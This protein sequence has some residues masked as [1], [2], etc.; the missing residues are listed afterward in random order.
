VFR[1]SFILTLVAMQLLVGSSRATYLCVSS[2]GSL[3]C[4]DSGPLSCSCCRHEHDS[5]AGEE[6]C[7]EVATEEYESKCCCQHDDEQSCPND[8]QL[9]ETKDSPAFANGA[10]SCTHEL[11]ST[12]QVGGNLRSS[13]SNQISNALQL[14]D[15]LPTASYQ[16]SVVVFDGRVCWQGPPPL[17]DVAISVLS[18]V[19]IRC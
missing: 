11:V 13:V 12:G 19:A 15:C 2:D 6:A 10:C 9:P 16:Q 5:T 8:S 3:C 14:L 17:P 18:T 4:L 7:C 1:L